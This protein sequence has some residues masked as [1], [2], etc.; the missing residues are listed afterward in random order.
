MSTVCL[1]FDFDAVSGWI[2]S[3]GAGDSPVKLSRGRYGATVA[4]PRLLDLFDRLDVSTTWFTPGHT[5]ESFPEI[6]GE[7]HDRGHDVQHHGWHHTPPAD[8]EDAD[9]ERADF[10][11]AIDTI[12]DLTG[13]K[14]T[15]Y[16]SPSWDFS[17][18]TLSILS[19]LGFEW[20]SSL[21][22]GDFEPYYVRHLPTADPDEPYEAGPETDI[23]EFPPSWQRDDWPSLQFTPGRSGRPV[24]D[25]EAVFEGWREQFDWMHEHV[26]DGVF[27]LTMHP[28]VT[29]QPP[30]TRYLERFVRHVQETSGA[31][32]ALVDDLANDY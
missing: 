21:M 9:A 2:H 12:Y 27:T 29:G 10:E 32:F 5:I 7:V 22:E 13:R 25:E 28:Q 17:P 16:R 24:A 4:A 30:R 20:D 6:A 15:G 1:C 3:H 18:H 8:F 31:S 26:D 14:P 19:D 23:L 11:R